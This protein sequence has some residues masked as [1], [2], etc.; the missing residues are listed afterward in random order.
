VRVRRRSR[1][2]PRDE[3]VHFCWAWGRVRLQACGQSAG[4]VA[5]GGRRLPEERGRGEAD[6]A[7][8]DAGTRTRWSSCWPQ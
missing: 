7:G 1:E 5:G 8:A 3:R 4:T 6:S 2:E